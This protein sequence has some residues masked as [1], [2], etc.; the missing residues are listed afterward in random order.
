MS[1]ENLTELGFE[2]GYAEEWANAEKGNTEGAAATAST[3][4]EKTDSVTNVTAITEEPTPEVDNVTISKAEHERLQK[5]AHDNHAAFTKKAQEAAELR[6][7][8]AQIEEERSKATAPSTAPTAAEMVNMTK[9]E[10][11]SVAEEFDT[12]APVVKHIKSLMKE[13]ESLKKDERIEKI[14]KK[15]AEQEAAITKQNHLLNFVIPQV[16]K[17]HEDVN[18]I[19]SNEEFY[20]WAAQDEMVKDLSDTDPI[21]VSFAITRFKQTGAKQKVDKTSSTASLAASIG[22]SSRS[23]ETKQSQKPTLEMF[24]ND[25]SKYEAAAWKWN[26]AHP[27]DPAY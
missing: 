3:P 14:V 27:T 12:L 13:V 18:E 15:D 4:E 21:H 25:V 2:A 23:T 11:D 24:G 10:L 16:A 22:S 19:L 5:I 8:L 6:G 17:V 26:E 1:E 9:D 20:K 7:R